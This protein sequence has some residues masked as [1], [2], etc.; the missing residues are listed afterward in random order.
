MPSLTAQLKIQNRL[1]LH[2]RPAAML[3]QTTNKFKSE[4]LIKKNDMEVNAKSIL[5]IM[6]LAAECGS[7]LVLTVSGEDAEQALRAVIELFERK[8]DEKE[9]ENA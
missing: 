2:A 6:M 5:G 1:G 9:E 4:I 3:V 7:S 8:F